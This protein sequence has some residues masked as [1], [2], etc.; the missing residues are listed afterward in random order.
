MNLP[1]FCDEY[2]IVQDWM[3]PRPRD[4]WRN[5]RWAGEVFPVPLATL[6]QLVNPHRVADI[7]REVEWLAQLTVELDERGVDEPL[8]LVVDRLGKLGLK[9]GHHRVVCAGRLGWERLP[10]RLI[11]SDRI[12]SHGVPVHDVLGSVLVG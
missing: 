9:D 11:R 5:G 10:C 8:V 6:Q 7:Q 12:R 4:A 2:L 3:P 1:E